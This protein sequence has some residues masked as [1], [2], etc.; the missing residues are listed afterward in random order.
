MELQR[1]AFSF[2]NAEVAS[3]YWLDIVY[4]MWVTTYLAAAV[5]AAG[6]DGHVAPADARARHPAA[7]RATDDPAA[8]Q[9]H[10]RHH[11]GHGARLGGRGTR[12]HLLRLLGRERG[13]QSDAAHARR[14]G[15]PGAF[16]AGGG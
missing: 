4:G 13:G 14:G 12:D 9:S 8:H 5:I 16:L 6:L 10:D 3:R 11:Q 1:L 15:L 7:G 2:F